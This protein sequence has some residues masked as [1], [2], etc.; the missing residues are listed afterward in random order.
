MKTNERRKGEM[1][2]AKIILA[3]GV[4]VLSAIL[5]TI[6]SAQEIYPT[7]AVEVISPNAAGGGLDFALQLFKPRVEKVLGKPL[8]INYKPGAGGIQG[9]LYAKDAKPDGYA[10]M[11]ATVSTLVLPTLT[12][13]GATYGMDDFTPVCNLTSIPILFCVKE[14]SP[15]KTMEDFIRAAKTK[16]MKYATPGTYYNVHILMEGLSRMAGF[17]ATHIPQTGTAAGMAAVMGGHLDMLVASS[18]GFAG[19]GKLRIL[20]TAEANRLDDYP[21]VQTLKEIGYPLVIESLDSLWAPR[22]VPK[23]IITVLFDA[24]KKAYAQNK[25]E[26]DKLGKTG[27]QKVSILTGDELKKKYQAQYDFYKK[28]LGEMG[29][30]KQ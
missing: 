6:V 19:P 13:K 8:I 18:S 7:R 20:A 3:F 4:L 26:M 15:Y 12:K 16:K 2:K 11:A 9:T 14:D 10:L 30:V 28:I 29:V 24:H 25:E 21:D 27:E 5:A 1:K 23:E 22:G 17:Q